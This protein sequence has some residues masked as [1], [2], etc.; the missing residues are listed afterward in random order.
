M[1][2]NEQTLRL[3]ADYY[4]AFNR[5]DKDAM[6]AL[7]DEDVEHDINMG[8]RETGRAAFQAFNERMSRCYQERLHELVIM[9]S[10]DGS[11]AAAEFVVHGRYLAADE[12]LPPAQGQTYVLPAGAFFAVR[13]GR[14]S[15]VTMYYN[16]Q[17][18]LDQVTR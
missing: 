1:S 4:A 10:A 14:I 16:L 13:D 3:I 12:G 9:A 5:D 15:R 6:L 17:H 8:A 7:L 11:R 2:S 18:W